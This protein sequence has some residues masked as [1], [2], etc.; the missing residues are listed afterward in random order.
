[1]TSPAP[2][3]RVR[4]RRSLRWQLLWLTAALVAVVAVLAAW[5]SY[6]TVRAVA[7]RNAEERLGAL[8]AQWASMFGTNASNQLD[9]TR[10]FAALP[11][12][13]RLLAHPSPAAEWP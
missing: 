9:A 6:A 8:A 3:A 13:Q 12:V 4:D 11:S 10:R 5:S 2:L 7:L 1:M